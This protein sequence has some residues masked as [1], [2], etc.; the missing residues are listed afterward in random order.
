MVS[1]SRTATL[2]ESNEM[3]EYFASFFSFYG[4]SIKDSEFL[5]YDAT[6]LSMWLLPG[7]AVSLLRRPESL[8]E[9]FTVYFL[10]YFLNADCLELT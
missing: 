8:N 5:E 7:N 10:I 3:D 2:F 6:L 9:Y 1:F 4:A